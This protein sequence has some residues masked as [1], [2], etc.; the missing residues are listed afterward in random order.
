M[1]F[2]PV[3]GGVWWILDMLAICFAFNTGQRQHS[4]LLFFKENSFMKRVCPFKVK[5]GKIIDNISE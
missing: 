2:L 5:S 1:L 4:T 3:L